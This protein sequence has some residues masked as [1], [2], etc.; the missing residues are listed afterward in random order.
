MDINVLCIEVSMGHIE[1]SL[2]QVTGPRGLAGPKAHT[3]VGLWVKS[4]KK[5]HDVHDLYID[6][7]RAMP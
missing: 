2:V 7:S 1:L 5:I 6:S 4:T 3:I